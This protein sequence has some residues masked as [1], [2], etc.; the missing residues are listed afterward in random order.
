MVVDANMM[1]LPDPRKATDAQKRRVAEAFRAMKDR[2]TLGFLSERR[3]RRMNYIENG[4]EAE[5]QYLSHETELTQ[6]DRRRLDGAVLE[7]LG[8]TSEQERSETLDD[9]YDYL[10][11]FFEWTRQKEERAIQNKKKVK[12]GKAVRPADLVREIYGEVERDYGSLLRTYDDFLDL[13]QPFDT[14]E[15]PEDGVPESL[16]GLFERHAIRFMRS[17][18]GEAPIV[19]T[20]S[21]VQRDLLMLLIWN[22]TRGFVRVPV[23]DE[24]SNSLRA[25]YDAFLKQRSDTFRTLVEERT[26]DP[27]LQERVHSG[28]LQRVNT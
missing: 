16:D 26:S 3:L 8:V 23:K 14:Y 13:S 5:L 7:M 21:D 17:K 20:R 18:N 15:V 9:L 22:G 25:R 27:E 10:A 2:P 1:R 4:K 6:P 24:A 12:K 11:E 28:L 19:E